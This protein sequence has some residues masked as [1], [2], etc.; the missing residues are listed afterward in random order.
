M[1][2]DHAAVWIVHIG[3]VQDAG[4]QQGEEEKGA[5]HGLTFARC[6]PGAG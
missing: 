3:N 2:G 6:W 5:D 1:A 4:Q